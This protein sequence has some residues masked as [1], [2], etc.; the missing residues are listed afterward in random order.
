MAAALD[1][2]G[3]QLAR[4]L[5][6]LRGVIE[7]NQVGR[8]QFVLIVWVCSMSVYYLRSCFICLPPKRF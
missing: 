7:A 1:P 5:A 4:Q 8:E 6:A 2:L 3:A